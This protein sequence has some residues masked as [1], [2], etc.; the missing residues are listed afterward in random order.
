MEGSKVYEL[1]AIKVTSLDGRPALG[2]DAISNAMQGYDQK[3]QPEVTMYMN[4]DGAS[5]WKKMTADA[6]A[7]TNNI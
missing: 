1:Y 5:K 7:D 4:S 3:N 6:A 2:G